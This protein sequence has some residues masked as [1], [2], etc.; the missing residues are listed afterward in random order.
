VSLEA[1]E[2][3]RDCA[4]ILKIKSKKPPA[5]VCPRYIIRAKKTNR[6]ISEEVYY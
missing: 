3:I 5:N 2:V 4:E 6:A 1:I